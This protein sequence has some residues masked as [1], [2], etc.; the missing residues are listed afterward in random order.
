MNSV[1]L[2]TIL[3]A[4]ITAVFLF[5]FFTFRV[6]FC[7]Y[8]E[9]PTKGAVMTTET[10]IEET[11]VTTVQK[12]AGVAMTAASCYVSYKCGRALL[13]RLKDFRAS[14]HDESEAIATA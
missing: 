7:S 3:G 6:F 4:V 10:P 11:E 5:S 2:K 14:R 9:T 1:S 12:V 8:N 13:R